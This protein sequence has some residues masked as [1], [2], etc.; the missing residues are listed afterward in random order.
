[1][2]ASNGKSAVRVN[3]MIRGGPVG[4]G[5]YEIGGQINCRRGKTIGIPSEG[6]VYRPAIKSFQRL[7]CP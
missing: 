2:D 3:C 1:M 4:V 6:S 5:I 7:I